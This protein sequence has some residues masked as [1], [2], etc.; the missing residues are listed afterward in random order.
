MTNIVYDRCHK[1]KLPINVPINID[2]DDIRKLGYSC[3]VYVLITRSGRTYIGSS[4]NIKGR[5]SYHRSNIEYI[6]TE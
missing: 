2:I 6:L 3:G 1:I 4:T 5:L